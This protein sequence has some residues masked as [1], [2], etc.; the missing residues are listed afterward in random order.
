[1]PNDPYKIIPGAALN[2]PAFKKS[3]DIIDT[4]DAGVRATNYIDA[5]DLEANAIK[6][7]AKLEKTIDG[8][9]TDILATKTAI[10]NAP[11][12]SIGEALGKGLQETF[13]PTS[14]TFDSEKGF[15]TDSEVFLRSKKDL[16]DYTKDP[17]ITKAA[18]IYKDKIQNG[19]ASEIYKAIDDLRS[20]YSKANDNLASADKPAF[21][22][23]YQNLVNYGKNIALQKFATDNINQWIKEG[24]ALN[25]NTTPKGLKGKNVSDQDI[26]NTMAAFDGL[27]VGSKLYKND[28][29]GYFQKMSD[30]DIQTEKGTRQLAAKFDIE[31]NKRA[32]DALNKKNAEAENQLTALTNR[33]A[34]ATNPQEK[35]TLTQQKLE[36]QKTIN[37]Y[38]ALSKQLSP[39]G[40]EDAYLKTNYKD[41]YE[42]KKAFQKLEYY[43]NQVDVGNNDL[44]EDPMESIKRSLQYTR[45]NLVNTASGLSS[46]FGGKE[47]GFLLG[48]QADQ[49]AP[50][51][52]RMGKD[53]N[54]NGFIDDSEFSKDIDGNIITHDTPIYTDAKGV[55]HWNGEAMFE[56]TIPIL[57]DIAITSL[58]T[59]GVGGLA[60][61]APA[62][63]LHWG[64]LG[65]TVGLSAEATQTL[66]PYLSTFGTVT[67]TTFPRFYAEELRNFKEDGAMSTAFL[68][69]AAEGLTESILPDTDLFRGTKGSKGILNTP[70]QK[71]FDFIGTGLDKL[72]GGYAGKLTTRMTAQRDLILGMLPKGA[73]SRKT[74][75]AL[76]VPGL[77][78]SASAGV[79]E[80]FEEMASLVANHFVDKY[81]ASQNFEY[82][83]MNELSGEALLDTFVTSLGPSAIIG[84]GNAFGSRAQKE[85]KDKEGN[86][87]KDKEGNIKYVTDWKTSALRHE[88]TNT[89]RWNIANNPE[90]YKKIISQKKQSGEYT[91][92]EA[93]KKTASIQMM[94][95]KLDAMLPE[96][97]SIKNLTTLLDDPNRMAEYFNDKVFAE[98]LLNVDLS[99]LSDEDRKDYEASVNNTANK[100][101]KTERIIDQ[102]SSLSDNDKLGIIKKAYQDKVDKLS[103]EDTTI[104]NLV[105]ASFYLD[106]TE[107]NAKKKDPRFQTIAEYNEQYQQQILNELGK[108]VGEFNSTLRNNPENLTLRELTVMAQKLMPALLKI[109]N[110][111]TFSVVNPVGQINQ[112]AEEGQINGPFQDINSSLDQIQELIQKELSS[113]RVLNE[114]ESIEQ[115]AM[116]L[117]MVELREEQAFDMA[118]AELTDEEISTGSVEETAHPEWSDPIRF[119]IAAALESNSNERKETGNEGSLEKARTQSRNNYYNF[120][121]QEKDPSVKIAEVNK[122]IREKAKE[123]SERKNFGGKIKT[124]EYKPVQGS[125]RGIAAVNQAVYNIFKALVDEKNAILSDPNTVEDDKKI[126]ESRF[127]NE[128]FKELATL[129]TLRDMY[130]ALAALYP[131]HQVALTEYFERAAEGD[132]DVS[133]LKEIGFS[134]RFLQKLSLFARTAVPVMSNFDEKEYYFNQ[135]QAIN[136]FEE[137]DAF[138]AQQAALP[139]EQQLFPEAMPKMVDAKRRT[140][141]KNFVAD[142][143]RDKSWTPIK[144]GSQTFYYKIVRGAYGQLE[145]FNPYTRKQ[146]TKGKFVDTIVR[147]LLA[148]GQIYDLM[149][150]G[151]TYGQY[152]L[153]RNLDETTDINWIVDDF[154][155]KYGPFYLNK[156]SLDYLNAADNKKAF[157][158]SPYVSLKREVNG[159][160]YSAL[161]DILN[162]DELLSQAGITPD[163]IINFLTTYKNT[164]YEPIYGPKAANNII[165]AE[166]LGSLGV[167]IS[168]AVAEEIAQDASTKFFVDVNT[169]ELFD[170]NDLPFDVRDDLVLA[171]ELAFEGTNFADLIP[172]KDANINF[173]DPIMLGMI[174]AVLADPNFTNSIS[175]EYLQDLNEFYEEATNIIYP[176]SSYEDFSG[177]FTEEE[178]NGFDPEEEIN[179]LFDD[180]NSSQLLLDQHLNTPWKLGLAMI[181]TNFQNVSQL[182]DPTVAF[183]YKVLHQFRESGM[184]GQDYNVMIASM[185][186]VYEKLLTKEDF[187]FIQSIAERGRQDKNYQATAEKDRLFKILSQEGIPFHNQFFLE[188][189]VKNPSTLGTGFGALIV[190]SNNQPKLFN[191]EGSPASTGTPFISVIKKSDNTTATLQEKALR[192]RLDQNPN[193]IIIKSIAG[194]LSGKVIE[195]STN[196]APGEV[197]LNSG[198][199]PI[200]YQSTFGTFTL[201][202]G[203]V[204]LYDA[205]AT[206]PYNP[207]ILQKVSDDFIPKIVEAYNSGKLPNGFP[208]EFINNPDAFVSYLRS[209]IY[210]TPRM[211]NGIILGTDNGKVVFKAQNNDGQWKPLR[212]NQTKKIAAAFTN[213]R[214]NVDKTALD[215]NGF[216]YLLAMKDGQF[217]VIPFI[218]YQEMLRSPEFGAKVSMKVNERFALS[219]DETVHTKESLLVEQIN[220]DEDLPTIVD[221]T[222]EDLENLDDPFFNFNDDIDAA[223]LGELERSLSLENS[224]T[225][226][227]NNAAQLWVENHPIFKNTP[228]IFNQTITHP[229][230]YA[231]WSKAGVFLYEGANYAEGYHEAWHEFSQFYLTKEQKDSLYAQARKIYGE[232]GLVELEEKLAEDFRQFALSNGKV[233]PEAIKNNMEAKNVFQK[234]WDFLNGFFT[235]KNTI[236]KYFTQLYK[237][238]LTSYTRDDSQAYFKELYSSKFAVALP[239]GKDKVF[240]FRE[241]DKILTQIDSLFVTL[242]NKLVESQKGSL[243]NVLDN[244]AYIIQTY[245]LLSSAIDQTSAKYDALVAENPTALRLARKEYLDLLKANKSA[246]FRFHK[247]SST[248]F[249]DKVR[250]TINAEVVA[251]A[252]ETLTEFATFDA[253]ANDQSQKLKA[254]PLIVTAIKSLPRYQNN[255][256]VKDKVFGVNE[257]GDFDTNWKILQRTLTG[258]NSY[259]DMYRKL[260]DLA[261][262]YGQFRQLLT[263]FPNPNETGLKQSTL[264]FKNAFYNTFSM[265]YLDGYTSEIT[266]SIIDGE[267]VDVDY[268]IYKAQSLDSKNLRRT[269][270]NLFYTNP[271]LYKGLNDE[272]KNYYLNADKYFEAYPEVPN[273]PTNKSSETI[274]NYKETLYSILI[275]LGFNFTE[276]GKEALFTMPVEDFY[277]QVKLIHGKIM[278]L[279]EP[280]MNENGV[281]RQSYIFSPLT[282]ISSEHI[283]DE[284]KKVKSEQTALLRL[285]QFEVTANVEYANDMQYNALGKKVWSVNP[286][287]Y[288]TRVLAAL[289]DNV[290]YPTIDDVF[291][292]YPQLNPATN[293]NMVSSIALK[294]LFNSN[295]SRRLNRDGSTRSLELANL[296]GVK[297]NFDGE[298]TVDTVTPVKH[299]TDVMGFLKLGVEEVNR[300]S[301]KSTTRSLVFGNDFRYE[302]GM[303]SLFSSD[304]KIVIP[305][306]IM[307]NVIVP[308]ILAEMHVANNP[309]SRFRVSPFES[310]N[311]PRLG[312]FEGILTSSLRAK[313]YETMKVKGIDEVGL[314]T[315]YDNLDQQVKNSIKS[316]FSTYL[317]GNV[318]QSQAFFQGVYQVSFEDLTKYHLFSF[319]SRIEQ[320]KLFYGHPYFY[321]RA[322]EIEKRISSWNAYG[323]YPVIDKQNVESITDAFNQRDLFLNHNKTQAQPV[324]V[325]PN[326]NQDLSRISYIVLAD[327]P[328]MSETAK[329]SDAYNRVAGK[330]KGKDVT[331]KE[332]YINKGERQ[333]AAAFATMDFYK[334]FYKLSTGVSEA[335]RL[336]FARQDTILK[337]L[338]DKEAGQD[339]QEKLD[340]A[341]NSGPFY[342]FTIKKLQYAGQSAIQFAESIPVFHKYSVKPILPSEMV[343]NP[344][345]LEIA[346]KLFASG[347]DYAVFNS[348]SKIVET[349]DP[350]SLY[351]EDG[352][353][354][355]SAVP[356]GLI[357]M[358]YLKEQV[359]VE[360]KDTFMSIFSTQF[361]K[362]AYKDS[363]KNELYEAYKQYIEELVKIDKITFLDKIEDKEKLVEYLLTELSK[364]N[365]AEATKDLIKLKENG[366][367]QHTLDALVD[368]TIMESALVSSITNDIIK[369]K[370]PGAQRVQYPVSLVRPGRTLGYYDL[371]EEN[372][373]TKIKQAEAIVSFSK[374][375]YPLLR[376]QY[377]GKAIGEFDV[378]GKPINLFTSVAKLNEALQNPVF[379]ANNK[380]ILDKA[381]TMLGIR[382]PGDDYHSMDSF[383]IVE[384]LPQESGEII[385]VPD[386][387]VIKAG[388]DFDI[389]KIFCYDP[390]IE[391]DGSVRNNTITPEQAFEDREAAKKELEKVQLYKK[392]YSNNI[393][394][395]RRRIEELIN[396]NGFD[397]NTV[398]LKDLYATYVAL[399][400]TQ[401]SEE[402]E[403]MPR[404]PGKILDLE[405]TELGRILEVLKQAKEEDLSAL[406]ESSNKEIKTLLEQEQ[407]LKHE[408]KAIRGR[409]SNNLLFNLAER[410]SQEE[411]FT[412]LLKPTSTEIVIDMA[413]KYGVSNKYKEASYTNIVNPIY[414][415][416]VHQ[417]NS[418]KKSL[419]VDAKSN[420]L[421]TILQKA[422]VYVID[423]DAVRNYPLP[424]NGK[425]TGALDFTQTYDHEYLSSGG[426]RGNR[427]GN[428]NGE[429]ISAHVDIER[430]D[431]VA[432]INLNNKLT[433]TANAMNLLG[434]SFEDIVKMVNMSYLENGVSTTSTIVKYSRGSARFSGKNDFIQSLLMDR[435]KAGTQAYINEGTSLPEDVAFLQGALSQYGDRIVLQILKNKVGNYL[436][437]NPNAILTDETPFGDLLRFVSWLSVEDLQEKLFTLSSN[438]DFDTFD[439]QNFESF[440]KG[441]Q[442]LKD[443]MDS[444]FFN[445]EG[446]M[447]VIRDSIISPFLLQEEIFDRMESIFPI[448]A[449]KKLTT[450]I[451]KLHRQLKKLNYRLNYDTFSRVFKNDLLYA[452]YRNN[453]SEVANYE[454]FLDKGNVGHISNIY[455]DLKARLFEREITSDNGIFD[456]VEFTTDEDSRYI[457]SGFVNNDID[458]SVDMLREDFSNGFNWSHPELDP[459]NEV[460]AKLQ[461]DMQAFFKLYAYAGII[462]TQLN[463][464]YNSYLP[465]IPE[466]VYTFPMSSVVNAFKADLDQ[467]AEA[468]TKGLN[469]DLGEGNT[470]DD[471]NTSE[472]IDLLLGNL[473]DSFLGKFIARFKE[474][475]PEF[476]RVQQPNV[477]LEFFK[478]YDFSRDNTT[479]TSKIKQ[480]TLT[481]TLENPDR[482]YTPTEV[483]ELEPNQVFVF[484]ANTAGHHGAGSAGYAQRKNGNADYTVYPVGTKGYWSEY[485]V[486]NQ[487]MQGTNGKSFGIVTKDAVIE[488]NKVTM[489]SKNSVPLTTI[490][491]SVVKMLE[492]ATAHPE[493]EFLV[494]AFGSNYAGWTPPQIRAILKRHRDEIP[495]NVILP[496]SYEVRDTITKTTTTVLQDVSGLDLVPENF[497]EIK[498]LALKDAFSELNQ[499]SKDSEHLC[500][501][502]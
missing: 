414:Q 19:S 274:R 35:E 40:N 354:D 471:G 477:D 95:N 495:D 161:E 358:A 46:L 151:R 133:I 44:L 218:S 324:D 202:K 1:M 86:V 334:R 50:L 208:S 352:S 380:E 472:Q 408:I 282:A 441:G 411:L 252:A 269:W 183:A 221:S 212:K 429:L 72:T 277:K 420:V 484:G 284:G 142:I 290:V 63:M 262:Q 192:A 249:S 97:K 198:Q 332:Y 487:L 56:Q 38:D 158:G 68:R 156:T 80:S 466:Q 363:E 298:K 301:G 29:L 392:A 145:I 30:E 323:A 78:Q 460:D 280:T 348:G 167:E 356:T 425:A 347:A 211:N 339:V 108:R 287:S 442:E 366:E 84:G 264:N 22:K 194:I 26:R 195:L 424:A 206:Y 272:N 346:K 345:L 89:A 294:Y 226:A 474:L 109:E 299:F 423:K 351:K 427:I 409:M 364:K 465:L 396:V 3:Q 176:L 386:E 157:R 374:G 367:L 188:Y 454:K 177:L 224:I 131:E 58:V 238:D 458:Y 478:D 319:V 240:S 25:K 128:F 291:K 457:R 6:E 440:R 110:T 338:L 200:T 261:A 260:K 253:A 70:I 486:V 57:T 127:L 12:L 171:M 180:I 350:V 213:L 51:S 98:E 492:V 222:P 154:L 330:Q 87:L 229:S 490:E 174:G 321:K 328:V 473:G 313:L 256:P 34:K 377:N 467:V 469:Q 479:P 169:G 102:Y 368:R 308:I 76:L 295:G 233:F 494:S 421:H 74:M 419:A 239:D 178:F 88:A 303:K 85:A 13:T 501:G 288:M 121:L 434:T 491:D 117:N 247:D 415:L 182:G 242:A 52:Y 499:L 66:R 164:P 137:L 399:T 436:V 459:T 384:F 370:V 385:L 412:L 493:L 33:I 483:L 73:V 435:M 327:T 278:G 31:Y 446:V 99:Q 8:S 130:S 129:R 123:E 2:T 488:N 276:L 455:A 27:T 215:L 422:G 406:L 75:A 401:K 402:D 23:S 404:T 281:V 186:T 369:Q 82:E 231:V 244:K 168:P 143:K 53:L 153:T 209:L 445:R 28:Y 39:Y 254:D 60:R 119:K 15:G 375:Y 193:Q 362:L 214:Y 343:N 316:Q 216:T 165:R 105:T 305:D 163:D 146:V 307:T 416:Y 21:T 54:K 300:F 106:P 461:E 140:L 498:R 113:R 160:K 360:N 100:L 18:Q 114:V 268:D 315:A 93:L 207:I 293:P 403:V 365:V 257:V 219:L 496:K 337:L 391:L 258:T 310:E 373:V 267:L 150:V 185:M 237:G 217:Q 172:F 199:D 475:H 489:K 166:V 309:S 59:R 248:L 179:I 228:F 41:L 103:S 251:D 407:A 283:N 275:P 476:T 481:S 320:H 144:V 279:S 9:L 20:S 11:E 141:Q 382:V 187:E 405:K 152:V 132:Y 266:K 398:K 223:D 210:L 47:T 173:Y 480:T 235:D 147:Q 443:L 69:A 383:R 333:D 155:R 90:T 438:T 45:S 388:S 413:K 306:D 96:M 83:Q 397:A 115:G 349:V 378:T 357:D 43:K 227:E 449:N 232:L 433:A 250:K 359:L 32:I 265:P 463:K 297:E 390:F 17:D 162:E 126:A 205:N 197:F 79:Q 387:M 311:V 317:A 62:K 246:L 175:P 468:V 91:A 485:G 341:L 344:Q 107:L 159:I 497:A 236:D 394:R 92:E 234:I 431:S 447:N 241:G 64:T 191:K 381:L 329:N 230:A 7:Q 270:D 335:M 37:K 410:L 196:N 312:Y 326:M 139:F 331:L 417:L 124:R 170:L 204:Y 48:L 462:G 372:G 259:E 118:I 464:K 318:K 36:T 120:A 273:I 203:G 400:N 389:D 376:L 428:I 94:A 112:A 448:S 314:R 67:A 500:K 322:K 136:T 302:L 49:Y 271:G 220:S 482:R 134:P 77:R 14:L 104:Q 470:Y 190:D 361:R 450:V 371:V 245:K 286:H 55:K 336:E 452:L 148:S 135:F 395:Y 393:S 4:A 340:E 285:I 65:K 353:L 439:P 426:A 263:Y 116:N 16:A 379:L 184:I 437:K 456:G 181:D 289:S 296:L 430:D 149:N 304:G 61:L 201:E 125:V 225:E 453:V 24:G 243:V 451:I 10:D 325:T 71:S 5:V 122:A 42:D 189:V 292:A 355:S 81:A 111:N 138:V 432:Q 418:F 502:S 101:A 255:R 444:N 342:S